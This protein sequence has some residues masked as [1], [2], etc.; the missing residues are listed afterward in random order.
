MV[1][2]REFDPAEALTR[3]MEVFAARGYA[4]TSMEDVVSATGV[5]R[6]GL[7]GTF[8]NKRELFEQALEKYA[9]HM[10]KDAFMRLFR[11]DTQLAHVRKVFDERIEK[12]FD[13]HEKSGCLVTFTAMEMAP[14]DKDIEQV[15]LKFLLRMSK[16]FS[17]GLKHA[18]EKGEVKID[19]DL[20]NA[21]Q[22]LTGAFFGLSVLSRCGFSKESLHTYVDSTLA[23]VAA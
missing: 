23:A 15:L 14:R 21:G 10:G 2:T 17:A 12:V 20:K 6:Y 8:G 13:S 1:R 22:F 19:L 4:N 7:Y 5:S 11:P 18:Q 3:A 9:E 16:A